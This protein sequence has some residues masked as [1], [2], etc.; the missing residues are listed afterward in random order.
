MINAGFNE[1]KDKIIAHS[2]VKKQIKVLITD[3]ALLYPPMW[4]GPKRIWNLY[5]NLGGRFDV[6]YVGID[7]GLRK[8]Y[9]NRKIRG[10][11]R[12]VIRPITKIYYL[13]R[14][15]ELKIARNTAFDIFIHIGMFFDKGFKQEL[16][17]H[18]AD[19]L[20]ASHPW[21]SPCLRIKKGQIF[22][23]D[24]HNC[25]YFLIKE[26]LK[27]RWFRG[28]ISFLVK[29]IERAA[30]RKAAIIIASSERD[31]ELFVKLYNIAEEKIF[32]VPNGA[33]M[34][35][36]PSY[37]KRKEVRLKL[38]ISGAKQVLLFIG[39]DYKPNIEAAKFIVNEV[40][41]KLPESDIVLLGSVSGYFRNNNTPENVR[42]LGRFSDAELYDWLTAVDIGINP[43]VSGSGMNMKML[44]YFSF[45]L[46]VITTWVGARGIDGV[47]SRDFIVCKENEFVEKIKLLLK[48]AGL[49][50]NL[51]RNA[52]ELA[53]K[54]YDWKKIS[55]KLS[56]ILS[57][58]IECGDVI[59]R[60]KLRPPEK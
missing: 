31:K 47:D 38:N 14:Y 22:I 7:C 28:A 17:K 6:T 51:G 34:E 45:G 1:P 39:T 60:E 40:A 4:G 24:A 43:M 55:E 48:N 53:E 44:D 18:E 33:C 57:D 19:I 25:E 56:R 52:R 46:P 30:C 37:E 10:N 12:E 29:L 15:F 3:T 32:I 26:I 41:S 58:I 23:Y 13:F 36:R 16:N 42:L 27:G 11:F 49:R 35:S 9:I 2:L 8:K 59:N 5:S 50:K 21:T 54:I 20:I